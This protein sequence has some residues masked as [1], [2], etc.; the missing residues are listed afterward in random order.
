MTSFQ[1]I[2]YIVYSV[3]YNFSKKTLWCFDL[4]TSGRK[5]CKFLSKP[6]QIWGE[7]P[8]T[9]KQL[10]V[11]KIINTNIKLEHW[12]DRECQPFKFLLKVLW[13]PA[14]SL[15]SA[16]WQ[17]NLCLLCFGRLR[18]VQC[19]NLPHICIG[20][21]KPHNLPCIALSCPAFIILQRIGAKH[22]IKINWM[23]RFYVF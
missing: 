21:C 19:E 14:S 16:I 4:Q 22:N 2:Y 7:W 12:T 15:V 3:K 23:Q 18:W 11:V 17:L 10:L 1:F 8:V 5:D 9:T 20:I 6:T 13:F